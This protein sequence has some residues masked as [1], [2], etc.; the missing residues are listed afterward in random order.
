MC[1][2]L[3]QALD[4]IPFDK[5]MKIEN[6][7]MVSLSNHKLRETPLTL[8]S[9]KSTNYPIQLLHPNK[10]VDMILPLFHILLLKR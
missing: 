7:V 6:S 9:K 1:L 5:F 10:G 3:R 8:W 4:D 2:T